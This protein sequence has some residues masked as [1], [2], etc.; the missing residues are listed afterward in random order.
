MSIFREPGYQLPTDNQGQNNLE[1]ECDVQSSEVGDQPQ[2]PAVVHSL[3]KFGL[4]EPLAPDPSADGQ[5]MDELPSVDEIPDLLS[6]LGPILNLEQ[7]T[8]GPSDTVYLRAR[9][10]EKTPEEK[11][12][13]EQQQLIK[14]I[15]TMGS[16]SRDPLYKFAY[17]PEE[18]HGLV[19]E[20]LSLKEMRRPNLNGVESKILDMAFFIKDKGREKLGGV[21]VDGLLARSTND[22]RQGVQWSTLIN[23]AKDITK[24]IRSAIGGKG[25]GMSN[26]LIDIKSP[27]SKGTN[28]KDNIDLTPVYQCVADVYAFK[29]IGQRDIP[30]Y[31]KNCATFIANCDIINQWYD[32]V[33]KT[34]TGVPREYKIQGYKTSPAWTIEN[35]VNIMNGRLAGNHK[36][37]VKKDYKLDPAGAIAQQLHL[38]HAVEEIRNMLKIASAG[39]NQ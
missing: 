32:S 29:V 24:T 22:K 2:S 23:C 37:G 39:D 38:G 6:Q 9:E 13:L 18:L 28:R 25:G 5:R 11:R 35:M 31:D 26:L 14:D 3:G 17:T 16:F 10:A 20:L 34:L 8:N 15:E 1:K 30:I 12:T 33:E 19:L 4:R 21:K 27:E 36:S 7:D